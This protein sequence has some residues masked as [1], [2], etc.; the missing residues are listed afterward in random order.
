MVAMEMNASK[1]TKVYQVWPG[2]NVFFFHGR[3]VCG[4]DPRGLLLTSISILVS[5]WIFTI[6]IANDLQNTSPTVVITICFLLTLMVIINLILVTAIDPGIIPRSNEQQSSVEDIGS[7]SKKV[8][9]NGV[10]QK[11]KYCRICRIFRPP[12]SC[13]CALCDNCV[14]K[15][16]HHC[17]WIGQCIALRNYRFYLTLLTTALLLFVY[18]FGFS[19]RRIVERMSGSDVGLFGML[20]SFPETVALT[21]FSFAAIWFLGCLAIFHSYL[22]AFN[23]TAY[24]NFRN[25]YEG[26]LN[27]YDKGIISNIK[28]VLIAPLPPSRVDFRAEVIPRW[29]MEDHEMPPPWLSI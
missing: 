14:E 13:H 19:C 24:E 3:L 18:I 15:F 9:V 8:S 2:K 28:E 11:L 21:L 12:R 4:P 16:D 23:Q 22:T 10:Q 17:P 26:S 27:P 29:S 20:G 5:T 1:R 7:S 6:Y 25:Q